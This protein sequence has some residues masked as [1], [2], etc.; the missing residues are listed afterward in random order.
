MY[1]CF[2]QDDPWYPDVGPFDMT[3]LRELGV[4]LNMSRGG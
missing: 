1:A 3:K 2:S 4:A